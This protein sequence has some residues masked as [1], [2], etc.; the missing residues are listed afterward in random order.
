MKKAML[1][2]AL[3]GMVVLTCSKKNITNNYYYG[4]EEEGAS[5]V[6]VV[7]PPESKATVTAYMGI[8]VASTQIDSVGYFRFF[9]LPPGS[10]TLLVQAKGFYDEIFKVYMKEQTTLVSD[11]I[12]LARLGDLIYAITPYNGQPEVRVGGSIIVTFRTEMDRESFE[13]AFSIEPA[14]EGTFN[15]HYNYPFP[16]LLGVSFNPREQLATSTVYKVTIDTTASDTS[17]IRLNEPYQSLFFT[18]P[19]RVEYVSPGHNS[20][21][22]SPETDVRVRFN[23][24]MDTESTEAA[25][26]MVNSELEDVSGYLSWSNPTY[27]RF[28]PNSPLATSETYMVTIETTASDAKGS[29]LPAP[30]WFSFTT[31][32]VLVQSFYPPDQSTWIATQIVVRIRFNTN[33]DIESVNSVFQMTD[34]KQEAVTGERIW[35]FPS[36]LDFAP[37]SL[38]AP[39]EIYTV[40]IGAGAKDMYG[41]ELKD[42]FSFWFRTRPE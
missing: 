2:L 33:M 15:W 11:T 39:N 42:F 14:V 16:D 32:P 27:M 5:I 30:F 34:S 1:L 12:F 17:G 35:Q 4:P 38:L 3:L 25:F 31:Q 10:Y 26:R 7:Y 19:I 40:T 20:A 23:T 29:R 28:Q 41:K 36:H 18:E 21:W 6:G 22:V 37:D 8:P 13:S 24:Y 9:G